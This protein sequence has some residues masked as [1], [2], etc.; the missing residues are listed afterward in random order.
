MLELMRKVK[1]PE[2][3]AE[4]EPQYSISFFYTKDG[5]LTTEKEKGATKLFTYIA[6]FRV[7]Y[8]D[9]RK[10]V[11]EVKGKWLTGSM[12]KYKVL[13]AVYKREQP[14]TGIRV[15]TQDNVPVV[16]A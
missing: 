16:H 14:E 13:V 10:E 1:G 5:R 9:G 15:I 4:I 12:L 6:D 11:I 2:G 3:I 8:N 7:V